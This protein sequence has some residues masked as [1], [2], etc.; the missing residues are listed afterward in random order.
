M[1]KLH[2]SKPK[3]KPRHASRSDKPKPA[4][5]HAGS[6]KQK[7]SARRFNSSS[8]RRSRKS[9]RKRNGDENRPKLTERR[10]G[11]E[12]SLAIR[13]TS[14]VPPSHPSDTRRPSSR[15]NGQRKGLLNP[16]LCGLPQCLHNPRGCRCRHRTCRRRICRPGVVIGPWLV[17]AV[18]SVTG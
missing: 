18:S 14:S 13:A 10:N 3:S 16:K 2:A 8:R 17:I 11:S 4:A 12:G 1:P 7:R 5:K 9:E 15:V 6:K